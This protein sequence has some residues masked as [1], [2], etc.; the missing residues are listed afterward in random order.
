MVLQATTNQRTQFYKAKESVMR[1]GLVKGRPCSVGTVVKGEE[2]YDFFGK[3]VEVV[4]PRIKDWKGVSGGSGDGNGNLMWA[5]TPDVVGT[6][7]EVEV[8]YDA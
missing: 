6:F 5:L 7:P 8:N 3:L 4:L 2:M 1:F